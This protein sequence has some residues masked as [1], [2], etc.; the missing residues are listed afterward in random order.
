MVF[1]L[2]A[3]TLAHLDRIDE[4]RALLAEA[5]TR[6]PG[7]SIDTVRSAGGQ[8]GPHSGVARIVDGLRKAGLS[9]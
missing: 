2:A 8:F 1:V 7:F 6:K 3:S 5:Q 4:A 9:E